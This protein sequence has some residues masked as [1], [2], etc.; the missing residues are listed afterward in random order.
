MS[1][2]R[3]V[4]ERFWPKVR[5][6]APNKCWL[7]QAAK[8]PAGYGVFSV[9][10]VKQRAHRVAYELCVRPIPAGMF[11]LHRCDT[12]ACVNPLHLFL[13]TH[14]DNMRDKIA[15][16]R[17]FNGRKARTQLTGKPADKGEGI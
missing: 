7:W 9:R 11:V 5:E 13:G 12:P 6:R 1:D 3:T 14:T 16:G 15:K 8:M 4:E 10:G 17:A 2:N